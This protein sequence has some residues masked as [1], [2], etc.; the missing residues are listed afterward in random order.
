MRNLSLLCLLLVCSL[1]FACK[2]STEEP[3]P[4][5]TPAPVIKLTEKEWQG[6]KMTIDATPP[7]G[8]PI[9]QELPLAGALL[10]FKIDKT[11]TAKF[12]AA[13]T[14][15]TGNWDMLENYTKLKLTGGFTTALTEV[16]NANIDLIPLPTGTTISSITIPEIFNI[17]TLSDTVL[18]FKG[19]VVV[20]L[21]VKV[22]T[23]VLPIPLNVNTD[24]FFK[25]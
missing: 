2:K 10:N 23:F 13:A 1:L 22:G 16:I 15:Q 7:S 8:A 25:R 6:D 5:V 19:V 17:K 21:S 11:F 4:D 3:T 9:N 20:N 14:P 12:T 24:F 18:N